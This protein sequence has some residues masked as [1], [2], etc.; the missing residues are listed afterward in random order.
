VFH[1]AAANL[2]DPPDEGARINPLAISLQ[3]DQWESDGLISDEGMTL[4]EALEQLPGI[5]E[6]D[7]EARAAAT[8]A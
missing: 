5:E 1:K 7:I 3:P 2:P 8:T 4:A 6:M